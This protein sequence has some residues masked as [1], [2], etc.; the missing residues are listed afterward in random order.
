MREK[1]IHTIER[2]YGASFEDVFK[3]K[4]H[5]KTIDECRNIIY[6]DIGVEISKTQLIRVY[7]EKNIKVKGRKISDEDLEKILISEYRSGKSIKS[8]K[9]KIN[10]SEDYINRILKE[11][12][13]EKRYKNKKSFYNE[14]FFKDINT[15]E[16]AYW[17]GFICA[18]GSVRNGRQKNNRIR[19][20][21]KIALSGVDYSHLVKFKTSINYSGKIKKYSNMC[22]ISIEGK[23]II[24]DLEKNNIVE[25]KTFITKKPNLNK[26]MERHFW[27]GVFDGD[28][29]ITYH[30]KD[31]KQMSISLCGSIFLI[32]E[33]KKF[34][35]TIE[36][37]KIHT[38]KD[39]NI[40]SA[41]TGGNIVC[42]KILNKLYNNSTIF[43]KRKKDLFLDFKNR[44]EKT[45]NKKTISIKG[46]EY[47]FKNYNDIEIMNILNISKTT[48][49]RYKKRINK[50]LT[51]KNPQRTYGIYMKVREKPTSCGWGSSK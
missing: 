38:R 18:D 26:N 9:D 16:K 29:C 39:R 40:Y 42:Y 20:T 50:N 21:L 48:I 2:L 30:S 44:Y 36:V 15:E 3:E 11:N 43:L 17:L 19:Y 22:E 28:G 51:T 37:E 8:I 32:S 7:K 4:F 49:W 1:L 14:N 47:Y 6:E 13:I 41:S 34:L 12:N 46:L 27:R 31:K 33:F 35:H 45:F 5:K 23:K 25:N 24:K 10:R